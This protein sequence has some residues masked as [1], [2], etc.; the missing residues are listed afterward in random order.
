LEIKLFKP[1]SETLQK[2]IECFYTLT[3]DS[4]DKTISYTSFPTNT[5]FVTLCLDSE[6]VFDQSN[7]T[8]RHAKGQGVQSI[9]ILDNQQP[10][11]TRYEGQTHEITI[12][13]KPLGIN[14]FLEKHFSSYISGTISNFTPYTDYIKKIDSI[15]S[16]TDNQDRINAIEDYLCGKVKQFAHPFLNTVIDKLKDRSGPPPSISDMARI[17]GISRPTLNKQ[18]LQHIGTTPSQFLKIERF[19]DAIKQFTKTSTK[20]Q[21][22]DVAY[23]VD[24][25]DQSHMAKDFK[26]LTGYPPKLFFSKLSQIENNQINWIF[27]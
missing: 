3:R 8:I 5:V 15:F 4:N 13:F 16:L 10:G 27:S 7:L 2:F 17:N 9:L 6:I 26:S 14:A 23:L 18:F 11:F 1:R 21:L 19:R 22:V 24:Y 20:E 25:F 12:Y